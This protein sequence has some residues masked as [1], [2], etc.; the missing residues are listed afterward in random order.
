MTYRF[1]IK[2]GKKLIF[3]AYEEATL[4]RANNIDTQH[5]LLDLLRDNDSMANL[6]LSRIGVSTLLTRT[7]VIQEIPRGTYSDGGSTVNLQLTDGSKRILNSAYD[8]MKIL[9][10][11]QLAPE[12]VLLGLI[13][14]RDKVAGHLLEKVGM[15]LTR[16][17]QEIIA[18]YEKEESHAQN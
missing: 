9:Q 10:R 18:I 14:E 16:A 17:R 6:V 8:E 13:L 7:E 12:H 11:S 4:L 15:T 3:Y 5:L 2:C 1:S